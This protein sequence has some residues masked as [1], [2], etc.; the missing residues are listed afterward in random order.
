[1]PEQLAH[2]FYQMIS[3]LHKIQSQ[4]I[5]SVCVNAISRCVHNK[6][7]KVTRT[8]VNTHLHML[9]VTVTRISMMHY[10]V[11]VPIRMHRTVWEI[12]YFTCVSYI[13]QRYAI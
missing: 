1:M 13:M 12:L 4:R 5:T 11:M 9:R 7:A 3:V 10:C 2:S 8:S 6:N